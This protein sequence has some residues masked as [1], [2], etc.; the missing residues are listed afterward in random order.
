MFLKASELV[1]G[2]AT[3]GGRSLKYVSGDTLEMRSG[4][5]PEHQDVMGL[6]PAPGSATGVSKMPS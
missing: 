1:M 4:G 6:S 2:A 3:G 5:T